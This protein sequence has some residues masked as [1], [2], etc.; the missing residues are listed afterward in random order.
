MDFRSFSRQWGIYP[1]PV[2]SPPLQYP[3]MFSAVLPVPPLFWN[4]L[5]SST[6]EVH[7]HLDIRSCIATN[8]AFV[9][10][11]QRLSS[12][13]T[14]ALHLIGIVALPI[15]NLPNHIRAPCVKAVTLICYSDADRLPLFLVAV[16]ALLAQK[17]ETPNYHPPTL[18]IRLADMELSQGINTLRDAFGTNPRWYPNWHMDLHYTSSPITRSLR[19]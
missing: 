1:T 5:Q 13:Q 9:N 18:V 2:H 3:R 11:L 8:L 14:L 17:A 6:P 15:I 10:I 19:V 16:S 4:P 12:L 7:T